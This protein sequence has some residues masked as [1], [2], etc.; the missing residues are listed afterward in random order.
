MDQ[1]LLT[2]VK[3]C[4]DSYVDSDVRFTNVDELRYGVIS[5][6]GVNYIVFRGTANAL[7]WL[8]DFEIFPTHDVDDSLVHKGFLDAA[9]KLYSHICADLATLNQLFPIV[10]TGHSLGAAI[11]VIIA[12]RF[13]AP[14]YTVGCPRVHN[15]LGCSP[16]PIT[17]YRVIIGGDP[18]P[19]VPDD[20]LWFHTV[21]SYL[22]LT[23]KGDSLVDRKLHD[24]DLY[25]SRIEKS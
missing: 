5:Q 18:V 23:E 22:N 21:K 6:D 9:E 1:N 7:S 10:V 24:I 19:K 3:L 2:T 15:Q 13:K 11:G 20:E 12:K 25:I 17:H 16:I 8:D 4:R 14:L